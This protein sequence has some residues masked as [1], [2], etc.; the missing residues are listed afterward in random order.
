MAGFSAI[1]LL[2]K[3]FLNKSV[4]AVI[5]PLSKKPV[6]FGSN[7]TV[8]NSPVTP[9]PFWKSIIPSCIFWPVKGLVSD[10]SPSIPKASILL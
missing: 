3:K 6:S 5:L 9:T 4:P 7:W 2:G 10:L 8:P 1:M